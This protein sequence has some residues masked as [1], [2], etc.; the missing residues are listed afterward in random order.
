[1]FG[2][3]HLE[4]SQAFNTHPPGVDHTHHIH[5]PVRNSFARGAAPDAK[6]AGDP[7]CPV[8][9]HGAETTDVVINKSAT[10]IGLFHSHACS[11]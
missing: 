4:K 1:M 11:T 10:L 3:G 7:E 2:A 5:D 6:L 9:L 8:G